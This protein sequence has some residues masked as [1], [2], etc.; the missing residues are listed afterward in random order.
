MVIFLPAEWRSRLRELTAHGVA[1]MLGLLVAWRIFP[2]MT[3][4]F[5]SLVLKLL[6]PGAQYG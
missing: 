3:H 2:L 1:S 4:P 5:F 6:H